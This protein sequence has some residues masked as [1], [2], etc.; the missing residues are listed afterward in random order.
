MHQILQPAQ[1]IRRVVPSQNLSC[2]RRRPGQRDLRSLP[3]RGGLRRA[4]L[5]VPPGTAFIFG[6]RKRVGKV[7]IPSCLH[8]GGTRGRHVLFAL[9]SRVRYDGTIL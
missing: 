4:I 7:S 9:P 5:D 6:G 3:D 1:R 2:C 8:A